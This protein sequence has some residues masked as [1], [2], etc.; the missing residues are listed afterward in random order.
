[1]EN[2]APEFLFLGSKVSTCSF[3]ADTFALG[4]SFLHLLTGVAPYEELMADIRCPDI[5]KRRLRNIWITD[6]ESSPYFV[7]SEVLSS[8][9]DDSTEILD[10]GVVDV[11][12]DTL[13]RYVVLFG[14]PDISLF[15]EGGNTFDIN[16]VVAAIHE[17]VG[18]AMNHGISED[19]MN[20]TMI[21]LNHSSA[22]NIFSG[23]H[24]RINWYARFTIL[25]HSYIFYHIS[26]RIKMSELSADTPR[27]LRSMLSYNPDDRFCP[28]SWNLFHLMYL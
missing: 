20:A 1:L 16:P 4:L 11:L 10:G 15:S 18:Q 14:V 3:A 23:S 8:L 2:T 13:Y 17:T 26:A 28:N 19:A 24:D 21:Y 12:Y 6:D 9:Q 27:W 5:L 22:W 25:L 7:I